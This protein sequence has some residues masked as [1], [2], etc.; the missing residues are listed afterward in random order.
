MLV[1]TFFLII[2]IYVCCIYILCLLHTFSCL[3]HTF[4]HF[5]CIAIGYHFSLNTFNLHS[6]TDPTFLWATEDLALWLDI[7]EKSIHQTVLAHF[8]KGDPRRSDALKQLDLFADDF[9][10]TPSIHSFKVFTAKGA[11]RAGQDARK[12]TEVREDQSLAYN[13][14][15]GGGIT[16]THRH[17]SVA[18][19]SDDENP[20]G[21]IPA[22]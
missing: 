13:D 17:L 19:D 9:L 18:V 5:H 4:S 21:L 14:G 12:S 20:D 6:F 1:C 16:S 2:K 15:G 8:N 3:L 7:N 11:R 22:R 10:H